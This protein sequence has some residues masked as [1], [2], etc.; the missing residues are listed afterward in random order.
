VAAVSN[1]RPS[2]AKSRCL[3]FLIAKVG[4]SAA[5]KL[6]NDE[7]E[8]REFLA[9]KAFSKDEFQFTVLF[10]KKRKIAFSATHVACKNHLASLAKPDIKPF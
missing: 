9:G 1:D 6:S 3:D 5:G 2:D 4:R 7:I 8:L 10:R